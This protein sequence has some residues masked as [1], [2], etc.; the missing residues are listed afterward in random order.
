[1]FTE[2][3]GN[4]KIYGGE[5]VVNSDGFASGVSSYSC[6]LRSPEYFTV[7]ESVGR[8]KSANSYEL[9][10]P[11]F[12]RTPSA[13][14][15]EYFTIFGR[16]EVSYENPCAQDVVNPPFSPNVPSAGETKSRTKIQ[17]T[18]KKKT[19]LA[20]VNKTKLWEI[21]DTEQS[22]EPIECI[23]R[24]PLHADNDLCG[25]CS[26]TLILMEDGFP[27][28]TNPSCGVIYTNTLDYSP[29]W[30]YFGADDKNANDPTRCGNPI[31]PLLVESSYGCK[32]LCTPKCSY[33]MKKIRKWTEW[34]SMPHREKSLY[35]EFQFITI[36]AQNAGIPKI[37]IDEAMII[38]KDISEQKIFRGLNRDG[39]KSASIY[40]SCR[41]N[42]CP[43]TSHEIAEIF[44]LD[45]TSAT[46]GC[47]MAV[48][49]LN[50]IERKLDPTGQSDLCST[51]PSAFIERYCSKL[52]MSNEMTMLARFVSS[53][54][55]STNTITDNTPHS[56]AAGIIY[57]IS[58][59][60]QLNISKPEIKRVCGVS[61]VTINKCYKKMNAIKSQLIPSCVLA[62]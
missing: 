19:P 39:I 49:I 50:N 37:F 2:N 4:S 31:N 36:M 44:K 28:C 58:Q 7:A 42:G 59:N 51:T 45:K 18:Q 41:L 52:N 26:T 40:I 17:K 25:L 43:R 20:K 22:T 12:P 9:R 55:E 35:D 56:I 33:E 15:P 62:K 48:N 29:E 1:M 61:E 6:E 34:Q 53:R 13:T 10:S 3:Q 21:F 54:V 24:Q 47:T 32:V 14:R 16:D 46:N 27:T 23:Y 57:F 30:R 5:A 38:H 11:E 8:S 60:C